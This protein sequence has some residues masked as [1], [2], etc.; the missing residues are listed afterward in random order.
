MDLADS[1]AARMPYLVGCDILHECGLSAGR[2]WDK[3]VKKLRD[4]DPT[5]DPTIKDSLDLCKQKYHQ[6]VLCGEKDVRFYQVENEEHKNI[7]D[8]LQTKR[9]P[10]NVFSAN[11]PY[12]LDSENLGNSELG[13]AQIA[14]V[15]NLEDGIALV[16]SYGRMTES[17]RHIDYGE[18]SEEI[19]E[20]LPN[21]S[22]IIAVENVLRQSYDVVWVPYKSNMIEVRADS[23]KDAPVDFAIRSHNHVRSKFNEEILGYEGLSHATNV[24]SLIENLYR[25]DEEGIV[26]EM[27]FSTQ[28]SSIKS[29]KMRRRQ[30]DLRRELYH[31][32]GT[33]ALGG[34]IDPY[35]ISVEWHRPGRSNSALPEVSLNSR[36]H[37][38]HSEAP[39][40][41]DVIVRKCKD[42]TDYDYVVS[43]I[44]SHMISSHDGC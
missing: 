32:S 31:R 26:V 21:V 17:R 8:I 35:R 16:F 3:T 30:L 37:E 2:G 27:A 1:L 19:A 38:L 5:S 9:P 14:A 22:E 7:I 41:S 10:D 44:K 34:Q 15:E 33:D 36:V 39:V 43:R 25:D 18:L 40:L 23:P 12:I 24:F 42:K 11:Y 20:R 6:H 4:L 28:T 13:N 29:E